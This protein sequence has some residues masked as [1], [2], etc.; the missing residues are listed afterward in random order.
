MA[1]QRYFPAKKSA[2]LMETCVRLEIITESLFMIS[3]MDSS[4]A[5]E[6][7]PNS[8][9]VNNTLE[10]KSCSYLWCFLNG[11][12]FKSFEQAQETI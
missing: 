5:S 1:Q 12:C 3:V 6:K 8:S 4:N 2:V 10:E 7:E 9:W 11:S